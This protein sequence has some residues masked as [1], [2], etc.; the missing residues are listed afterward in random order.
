M[1]R[2][3][4]FVDKIAVITGG[5]SGL[6]KCSAMTLA[7]DGAVSCIFD[8]D[9]VKGPEAV[10]EIEAAANA[11]VAAMAEAAVTLEILP[12]AKVATAAIPNCAIRY[13]AATEA[14]AQVEATAQI[15]LTQFGGAVPADDFYYG[16]E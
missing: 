10:K 2:N 9:T 14:K 4:R 12:N 8:L 3:K 5:A 1:D 15:D 6:G 13:A 7:M 11:E 16:A